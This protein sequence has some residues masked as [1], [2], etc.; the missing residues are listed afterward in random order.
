[1]FQGRKY[2]AMKKTEQPRVQHLLLYFALLTGVLAPA[3]S[4]ARLNPL[5]VITERM[6]RVEIL[7]VLDTSGS[8]AW[9][10]SPAYTVGSDCG[11]DR[12][13]SVDLCGDGMCS[14][15][16]G[17]TSNP[18]Q[19]DCNLSHAYS[20]GAGAAP[21]CH[22]SYPKN[23][24]MF[25]VKRV[26]R[27]LLPDLTKSASFG[28]LT[29]SQSGYYRYSRAVS[30]AARKVAI[31]LSH[32]EL[33]H[34]N[35]WDGTDQR[36][37][38]TFQR[39]GVTYTLLSASGMPVT[40]DS[41][42]ARA[43]DV[44]QEH[45][46]RFSNAGLTH[47]DGS[48]TWRY[49]GS[50]YVYDQ[51][52]ADHQTTVTTQDYR[53]PQFVD[54]AGTAWVHNRFDYHYASR[55]I[56][57]GSTGMVVE[58]LSADPSAATQ[59]QV[60]YRIFARLNLASNGG[61]WAWG[62]TPTGPA[63]EAARQYFIDRQ[64][65]SGAF[66]SVGPDPLAGCRPRYVLLL[67][68]GQSNSGTSPSA[69]ASM[70]YK[71]LTLGAN[72]VKT[73][74]VALPGLPS[75][76]AGELD[77]IA[78][79]GDDGLANS[80]RTAYYASDETALV[81]VIEGA[82]LEMLQG[83]YTTTAP[84][85]T[86]SGH[87]VIS[88]D[89]ALVPSTRYPG[90]RGQLRA[91][92]LTKEPPLELWNAGLQL[93]QRSHSDRKI[94]SGL[95]SS[96]GGLP[97]PLLSNQGV[98]NLT[99]GCAGC[100]PVGVRQVWSSLAT[101]PTDAQ[102]VAVVEWLAGKGRTWKLGPV[103]RSAPATAGP[104]PKYEDVPGHDVFRKQHANRERLV[105]VTSN[106]GLLHAFRSGDGSEAFAYVP[107]N[108]WPKIHAL[109]RQGGQAPDPASFRWILASSARV[110]DAPPSSAG[111][112]WSTHLLL[113]MG[114]GDRAFA[115]LDITSPS[116]CSALV[117]TLNDP[118]FRILAHSRDMAIDSMLG[119]TWSVPV[120]FYSYSMATPA[121]HVG[122]GS[123]YGP[124]SV[125]DHYLYFAS[126]YGSRSSAQHSP[127]GALVDFAL[128]SNT[129]AAVD[130]AHGKEVIATYQGDL[131]GRL[132]RYEKGE[133]A[134]SAAVISAGAAN[135]FYYSPAVF[136]MGNREVLVAAVAGSQ[137]EEQSTTSEAMLYLRSEKDSVVDASNHNVTCPVS[138]ICSGLAP[139]PSGVPVGCSAPSD[140][141]RPVGPPLLLKNKLANTS[142]QFEAFY[143]VYDP[144]STA[145]QTGNTWLIR[146]ATEGA[147]QKL[148]SSTMYAKVRASG[149]S[150]AGGRI[151]LAVSR[152]GTN[153]A[154]SNVFTV[155]SSSL[156]NHYLGVTPYVESWRPAGR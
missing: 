44:S 74:V 77:A 75:T 114:P 73:L 80:S 15:S 62:G 13:G 146:V 11:G 56:T 20:S 84:G 32:I 135:P 126:L 46:F 132:V 101:P 116:R 9:Y 153:G 127:A 42:Y 37:V 55:G 129:A 51:R 112:S 86:T 28:L 144:P 79:M 147:N 2:K 140:R 31:F 4:E 111:G 63:I 99:G 76:A 125:G 83:D 12:R 49:R 40:Q 152:I 48:H 78:D 137:D 117:C 33:T 19:A 18:C 54:G 85:V 149:L 34:L 70:L 143:L 142:F 148:I 52:P 3:H 94:Y 41:L 14:G 65:G 72:H 122:M 25:I 69:A 16:E 35:A 128:V 88:G 138:A 120:F 6:M 21:S 24:R 68:D 67:T 47:T 36:P 38:Q 110:E 1:M 121:G 17:S 154:K 115:V 58:H 113:T 45:R 155:M 43:D 141:A 133:A 93:Q 81:K 23:S 109:W 119:E 96:N 151:D 27:N 87:H 118:P 10:P 26:L 91:L 145:C 64:T 50:Y 5:K 150:L 66:A 108:L 139:C 61:L 29:F 124:G 92:D 53:G 130:Q 102:I 30:G 134:S 107:P 105:Y 8:M 123:G 103:L 57:A 39:H 98:V 156:S 60:M 106:D 100:G 82:F 7:I 97:V 131:N 89:V 22:P 71:D 90:W 59:S 136:H 95:P 104:P